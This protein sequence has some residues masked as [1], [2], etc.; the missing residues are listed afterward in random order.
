MS[1][2]PSPGRKWFGASVLLALLVVWCHAPAQAGGQCLDS[3]PKTRI[4]TAV[5]DA[6]LRGDTFDAE[7]AAPK[8]IKDRVIGAAFV[9]A[10]LTCDTVIGSLSRFGVAFKGIVIPETL[11]LQLAEVPVRFSCAQCFIAK[12]DARG[13]RWSKALVLD[14]SRV[15]AGLTFESALFDD[16]VRARDLVSSA[17]VNLSQTSV[18]RGLDLRGMQ[19]DGRLTVRDA[20]IGGKLRLDGARLPELDLGGVQIGGQLI[21][22]GIS[23]KKHAVL[24]RV[25]IGGDLLLRTYP[26]GPEPVIGLE[27]SVETGTERAQGDRYVLSLNNAKIDGRLEIAHARVYGSI[28]LDAVRVGEDIWLRDCSLVAGPIQMPFARIGQNLDLSTSVLWNVDA[29]GSQ[30]DGELRLGTTDSARLTAPVWNEDTKIVLRN[31][32]ASAWV[33]AADSQIPRNEK[34]WAL[35]GQPDPWPPRIDVIGFSY[36]RAGGLGGGIET[37]R[38]A[39]WYVAWLDR[40]EPFS[41]DPYRRLAAFLRANGRD[42]AAKT[43]LYAGKERQLA[44]ADGLAKVLLLLQKSF[45]GYGIRTW[46]IFAWVVGFVLIG[47][48]VFSRTNETKERGMPYCLAYSADMFLPFVGLRNL[49]GEIDFR[50][51]VRYYL[52]VHKLMGWV[53]ATFFLSALAGLFEV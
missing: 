1:E 6:L 34:C 40:Q 8:R 11:D 24:D 29:T 51:P 39:R 26:N 30:I 22:S 46:Y 15:Q 28:S 38:R 4:E 43:L 12:I 33:D 17:E 27:Y 14:G 49:H 32:S 25:R 10:I 13:S 48:L 50:G 23:I 18:S 7:K 21:L 19:A 16:E 37:E 47:A 31:V 36:D 42:T 2:S 52:Y 44:Q 41:L 20:R 53:C 45:V 9:R 5:W 35:Q 3:R